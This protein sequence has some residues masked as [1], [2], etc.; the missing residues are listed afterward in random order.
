M[1]RQQLADDHG[2]LFI[3]PADSTSGF[4]ME[5]TPLPLAIAWI[6]AGGSIVSQAEMQ[7][8]SRAI[9]APN[10]IYRYAL[11]LNKNG[12]SQ[13]QLGLGSQ[14]QWLDGGQLKPLSALAQLTPVR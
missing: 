11:E 9:H 7:P 8:L 10:A 12:F 1:F 6:D 14:V 5:N 2:M 3:F 4:W 13:R